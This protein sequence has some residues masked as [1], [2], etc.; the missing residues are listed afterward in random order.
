MRTPVI[1]V[2]AA[3]SLFAL[4]ATVMPLSASAQPTKAPDSTVGKYI[5]ETNSVSAAGVAAGV[6]KAGGEIENVYSRALTGFAARMTADQANDLRSDGHVRSVTADAVFHST[7]VQAKP[8]WGLDRID[9]R[10]TTG[11]REYRYD[12]TGAG[13]TAYVVDTGIRFTHKQFGKRAKSGY[14]FVDSDKNAKDCEGHGTHV[15]GTIGGSTYGAAKGVKLVAVRVLDCEGSGWASDIIDGLDWVIA[16]KTGP[17]VVNMSLGGGAYAPID[18]AVE[19]TVDA[20]ISVV[21][22]AG[23]DG[24]D[25][26]DTSPARAP[27]AI[28]VAATDSDDYRA[29]FSNTGSCVDLFAPGVDVKSSSNRSNTATEVLSGTSMATPHVVGLAA[30]YLQ[31][32]HA[33]TPDQVTTALLA[34]ATQNAVHDAQGTPNLLLY[35]AP[36]ASRVPSRPTHVA[37]TKKATSGKIKW[38]VPTDN[39]DEKITGYLV[40]RSGTDSKGVGP[41]TRLV[42]AK[43][44]KS[45]F[46]KLVKGSSYTLS[47]QAVNSVGAGPAVSITRKW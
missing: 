2:A 7:T 25:A 38:S 35:T 19:R 36:P 45:T 47:V 37:V 6:R 14:D 24:E 22:A 17:S 16:H 29:W 1:G 12:T 41:I 44:R 46:T 23:N 11:N 42:S 40:S 15:S 8:T 9:Q 34:G 26:C 20:G 32:H 5:V 39:G 10:V 3:L 43:T 33:A 28:T 4:S 27:G 13:V 18:T 21:V 30:R 31:A